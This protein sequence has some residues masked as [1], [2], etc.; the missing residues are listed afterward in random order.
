MNMVRICSRICW[1]WSK[2]KEERSFGPVV[3]ELLTAQSVPAVIL[4][5]TLKVFS[6]PESVLVSVPAVDPRD[7][8][9][10]LLTEEIN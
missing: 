1:K 10:K 5:N 6:D 8:T 7:A 3:K 2:K 4:V 9:D